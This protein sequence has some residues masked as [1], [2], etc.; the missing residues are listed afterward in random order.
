LYYVEVSL[1]AR[2]V[3]MRPGSRLETLVLQEMRD[4][5]ESEAMYSNPFHYPHLIFCS[6]FLCLI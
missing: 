1:T 5:I 6:I 4:L 3:Q 2:P